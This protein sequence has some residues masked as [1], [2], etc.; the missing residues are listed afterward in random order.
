MKDLL[1]SI[2][3]TK[4]S[5]L[6]KS[7]EQELV[8]KLRQLKKLPLKDIRTYK[9]TRSKSPLRK[10]LD[11]IRAETHKKKEKEISVLVDTLNGKTKKMLLLLEKWDGARVKVLYSFFFFKSPTPT[12]IHYIHTATGSRKESESFL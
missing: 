11:F 1:K 5:T 7:R 10:R 2:D 3:R 12:L 4:S 8:E 6:R 9:H